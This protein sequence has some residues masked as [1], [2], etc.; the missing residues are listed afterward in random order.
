M[1]AAA[2]MT[3]PVSAFRTEGVAVSGFLSGIARSVSGLSVSR[4][5]V[6]VRTPS[7]TPTLDRG[8]RCP[9]SRRVQR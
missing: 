9:G 7:R 2:V 3:C 6:P 4:V 1:G 5:R 8:S